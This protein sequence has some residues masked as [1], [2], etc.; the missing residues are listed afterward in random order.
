MAIDQYNK[1]IQIDPDYAN[2]YNWRGGAYHELGQYR[3]AITNH[4]KA[5]QIDPDF[6]WA[7][8]GRGVA[9]SALGQYRDAITNHNKAIQL[10]PDYANAYNW[11]GAAYRK[12]GQY[13]LAD[14]DKTKACSLDSQYCQLRTCLMAPHATKIAIAQGRAVG[15]SLLPLHHRSSLVPVSLLGCL[16]RTQH[17]LT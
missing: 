2:V 12:L 10:D 11:R 9:Y 13:S 17:P 6:A 15:S 14:A 1:A 5:I 3:D 7:Y 4:N 8:N 16:Q